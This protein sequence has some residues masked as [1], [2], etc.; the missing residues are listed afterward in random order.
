M[1]NGIRASGNHRWIKWVI[2]VVFLFVLIWIAKS[3]LF[4]SP[5][6]ITDQYRRELAHT[7]HVGDSRQVVMAYLK[8]NKVW[9]SNYS[10]EKGSAI[11]LFWRGKVPP[12]NSAITALIR[13]RNLYCSNIEIHY[14][15]FFD[16]KETVI[17]YG[18]TGRCNAS[19]F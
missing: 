6:R 18:I 4:I 19:Q 13:R 12:H 1:N 7:I 3:K 2:C 17:D 14:T 16:K 15:F 10:K 9:F 5:D 8:S 11:S